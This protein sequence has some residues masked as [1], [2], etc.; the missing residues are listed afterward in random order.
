M[1]TMETPSVAPIDPHIPADIY[2]TRD[3]LITLI[4]DTSAI[5][6]ATTQEDV[7]SNVLFD[8][9]RDDLPEQ[10]PEFSSTAKTNNFVSWI[11]T[12]KNATL[13]PK[14]QV[15]IYD[16][17]ANAAVTPGNPASGFG[18]THWDARAINRPIGPQEYNIKFWVYNDATGQGKGFQI[19]PR[20]RV[21]P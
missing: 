8:D 12:V 10:G 9:N 21:N 15:L 7:I 20:I 11:G 1:K 6:G 5:I 13:Y 18:R 14:D 4:V 3:T 16:V 19:D 17:S 2:P